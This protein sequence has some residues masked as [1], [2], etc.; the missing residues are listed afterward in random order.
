[1]LDERRA[2]GR[3]VL[4]MLQRALPFEH[5]PAVVVVLRQLGEDAAEIDL[6]VAQRAEAA[7]PV[8]PALITRVDA[9]AAGRIELGV[10]DVERLDALVIDV[11]EGQI[12]E[13][14]Q[15]EVR[16]VVVDVAALVAAD[17]VEEHLEG[18]AVEHVLAG[19]NLEA[20]VDAGLVIDVED[21]FPAAAELGERLVDQ[22]G[23]ALRPWIE[24]GEGQ[25]T[26]ERH[27]RFQAEMLRGL[28]GV[29]DLLDRPF[30]PG[31]R[32][33]VVLGRGERVEGGV[34]GRMH[35]DELALQMRRQFGDLDAGILADALHLVAIGLGLSRL[36][37]I[38]QARV[39]GRDLDA[40]VAQARP[41]I[42]RS[43]A[44]C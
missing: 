18:G 5:R 14:L 13:L 42:W 3:A 1:M 25:R 33:V 29:L 17:R 9:L 32:I 12:V 39:P 2:L 21:R 16:R 20:D 24:I 28:G 40:L 11:D 4:G 37:E 38:E 35:R 26:G 43:T 22:A 23:R 7:G 31:L 6:P 8:D 19:M 36:F 27:R 10:L 34:I 44:G 15:Q 41:P 30:L